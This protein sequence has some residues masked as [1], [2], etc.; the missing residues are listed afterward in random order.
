MKFA[1]HLGAHITPEWRKQYIQYEVMKTMLYEAQEQAP[2][3]EVTDNS[4]IQRFF[5]RF[6]EKFFQFCD[7]ELSKINTFFL[8]K[9]SEAN[10]KYANLKAELNV[11]ME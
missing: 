2:S 6:D 7:A 1:E 5:A 8:E 4:T 10:R 9:L 3:P 11:Y